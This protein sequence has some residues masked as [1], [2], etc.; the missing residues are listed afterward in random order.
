LVTLT[1]GLLIE[2]LVF[3]LPTFVNQG[4][5]VTLNRPDFASSD[6]SYA[7][8]CLVAFVVVSLFI[9]NL[10]RSTT[11]LAL[12]AARWSEAGARTSGIS[13]VQMKV[14][15]GAI[16]AFI[17][18]VGGGLL[19]V[20]QSTVVPSEFATFAGIVWF[21]ALVTIGIRS[22]AAALVAGLAFVMLPAICQ[23]YLPTWT[24]NV[25]PVVFGMGAISA[26]KF[27]DGVLAEQSRRLRQLL[28][29]VAPDSL[30]DD[31]FAEEVQ[32]G[33]VEAEAGSTGTEPEAV[34]VLPGV[35]GNAP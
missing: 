21:A 9:V 20:S 34:S 10:R 4:L 23:A 15:A 26:A 17:A 18:G 3:T 5:G 14:L 13:V 19:A 16:A 22:T 33:V 12:N 25:L 32:A 2:N 8:L 7:Y 6:I 27:P 11:G 24:A 1:F 29:R 31:H 35:A 30:A 28:S